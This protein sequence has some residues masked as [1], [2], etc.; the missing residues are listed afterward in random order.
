MPGLS[1]GNHMRKLFGFI[2]VVLSIAAL[3]YLLFS[4]SF[5]TLRAPVLSTLPPT[6]DLS[7]ESLLQSLELELETHHPEIIQSLRPGITSEELEH[8]E[9]ILGQAIH[10]EMQALYSWHNGLENGKE[11]FPG[12]GFWSLENAIQT[13][14]ELTRQYKEKGVSQ[15]MAHEKNWLVLFPDIAGDG[16]YDPKRS[17]DKGGIFYNFREANYYRFFPSIKNLLTAIMECYESGAY[18]PGAEPIFELEEQIMDK[19]GLV[20]ENW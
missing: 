8:A 13:N 11:L 15:M 10:P 16:Y 1:N 3:I 6:V 5:R 2:L 4:I 9:T 12:H 19:Y 18:P 14:Q 7:M 20:I 17:Y